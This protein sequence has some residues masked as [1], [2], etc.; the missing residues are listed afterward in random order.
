MFFHPF[1]NFFSCP[2]QCAKTIFMVYNL[3]LITSQFIVIKLY[4]SFGLLLLTYYYYL[5]NALKL[6]HL[7]K[8]SKALKRLAIN[9]KV[10]VLSHNGITKKSA[11][12]INTKYKSCESASNAFGWLLGKGN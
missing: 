9:K 6:C 11:N 5:K 1:I 10:T 12:F 2:N 4:K 3:H 7:Q 8:P